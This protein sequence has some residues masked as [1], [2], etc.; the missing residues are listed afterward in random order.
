[1]PVPTGGLPISPGDLPIS[2]GDLAAIGNLPAP[3]GGI[4]VA[5]SSPTPI[6]SPTPRPPGLVETT[7]YITTIDPPRL[8]TGQ[9]AFVEGIVRAANG[10][11]VSAVGSEIFI[12][13]EKANGGTL[14]GTGTVSNNRFRVQIL[15]PTEL[16]VGKYQ[17][18]AHT[19]GNQR[20]AESWSDPEIEVFS[21][22]Q[23]LLQGPADP[24]VGQAARYSGTLTT[25]GGQPIEGAEVTVDIGDDRYGLATA[26]DGEFGFE[27]TFRTAGNYEV[28]A[29]FRGRELNLPKTGT[30]A[31]VARSP[32]AI[33]LDWPLRFNVASAVQVSGVVRL[34]GGEALPDRPLSL[35]VDGTEMG[36]IRTGADGRFKHSLSFGTTGRHRLE[37]LHERGGLFAEARSGGDFQVIAEPRLELGVPAEAGPGDTVT[38]SGSLRER[39]GR[40]IEG[41]PVRVTSAAAS[42]ETA[43]LTTAGDGVFRADFVLESPGTYEFVASFGGE[44][45]L[46]PAQT[47]ARVEIKAPG[48]SLTVIASVV[49]ALAAGAAA[50]GLGATLLLR[51]MGARKGTESVQAAAHIVEH[52]PVTSQTISP[53]G[54]IH[55]AETR[56]EIS[57]PDIERDLPPVWGV[58]DPL[59]VRVAVVVVAMHAAPPT[60][61]PQSA[62]AGGE[63]RSTQPAQPPAGEVP[64]VGASGRSSPAAEGLKVWIESGTD[65]ASNTDASGKSA[66]RAGPGTTM[67]LTEAG[68]AASAELT[69]PVVRTQAVR[70]RFDGTDTLAGS[71]TQKEL[72]V[73]DYR[74][75]IVGMFND[76]MEPFRK[77]RQVPASVTPRTA[78]AMLI[79]MSK[80]TDDKAL[81][82]LVSA[83][84]LA[85]YSE[86]PV[87]RSDWV[88]AY[89]AG[90]RLVQNQREAPR[91]AA[92][93]SPL[94]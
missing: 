13:T 18:I 66:S 30:L 73:V 80:A 19:V 85:E 59:T 37:V 25:D 29:T 93:T 49:A 17:V 22:T 4:G 51:R 76:Y 67:V 81:D 82:E 20:F 2:P 38:V 46:A 1:M 72:R 24:T 7:T 88:R 74:A 44:N 53:A 86:H 58:G 12:N 14:V 36:R 92:G 89:R 47:S 32:V 90:Q 10:S 84:E 21:G 42:P 71:S 94:G 27:H 78:E 15:V 5:G 61:P 23:I 54:P 9:I 83:F 33:E 63:V 39:G 57:C 34:R 48:I 75:E 28:V 91:V 69:F 41:R 65:R 70:A 6:A 56:L 60:Q 55:R 8:R 64:G 43:D 79:S 3:P 31:V 26:R 77:A 68:G 45:D 35:L 50:G 62:A 16:P 52:A 40:G 11:T 87:N